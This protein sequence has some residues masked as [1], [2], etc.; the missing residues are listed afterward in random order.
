M[1]RGTR[2]IPDHGALPFATHEYIRYRDRE[3][4]I[5]EQED[6]TN[7]VYEL[8]GYMDSRV[9]HMRIRVEYEWSADMGGYTLKEIRFADITSA[10]ERK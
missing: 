4:A 7:L 10:N 6:T 3:T 9:N 8:V 2:L 5:A 1:A